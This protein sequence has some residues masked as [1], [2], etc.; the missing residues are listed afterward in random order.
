MSFFIE[1]DGAL[2]TTEARER[3]LT[4]Y[5][6][7]TIEIDKLLED[8]LVFELDDP[9]GDALDLMGIHFTSTDGFISIFA[10]GSVEAFEFIEGARMFIDSTAIFTVTT[11]KENG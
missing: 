9:V 4:G 6:A 8:T 5:I 3:A 10:D 1:A 2:N 7:G 11:L